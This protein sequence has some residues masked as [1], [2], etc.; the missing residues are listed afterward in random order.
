MLDLTASRIDR[1]RKAVY[2]DLHSAT[3]GARDALGAPMDD[4]DAVDHERFKRAE[5]RDV[6]LIAEIVASQD[7]EA[8]H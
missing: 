6:R 7:A 2:A 8:G 3:E 1:L 5:R 4:L